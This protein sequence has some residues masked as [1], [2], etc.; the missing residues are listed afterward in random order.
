M[1]IEIPA[2]RSPLRVFLCHASQD[3]ASVR[4]LYAKL[5]EA[6]LD[7]WLDE[8]DLLPG[9]DWN[10]EIRKAV[11]TADAVV[12]CL[13]RVSSSKV[14][15]VQ[16]EIKYALD[17]ADER[18]PGISFLFPVLLDDCQIPERFSHI[19]AARLGDPEGHALLITA[20]RIHAA[21]L[22]RNIGS[23]AFESATLPG[24]VDQFRQ[25]L[26]LASYRDAFHECFRSGNILR[27]RSREAFTVSLIGHRKVG[28]TAILYVLTTAPVNFLA[29]DPQTDRP[30]NYRVS[31]VPD[32]YIV[33]HKTPDEGLSVWTTV[34]N[35]IASESD[36]AIVLNS[37]TANDSY[38]DVS[39]L[40]NSGAVLVPALTKAD[41]LDDRALSKRSDDIQ[42]FYNKTPLLLSAPK[43]NGLADLRKWILDGKRFYD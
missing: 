6:G 35:Y 14:G 27:R 25:R 40:A 33:D 34:R 43:E 2:Q 23:T 42:K 32:V 13:S 5:K 29:D 31:L 41:L 21:A 37:A 24:P 19:Q 17:V 15:F 12:V 1:S 22:G 7:P 8:K 38:F 4:A 3:K 39:E 9:Q 16:R 18:P 11:R 26:F 10:I 36:L 20:L 28:K 30:F